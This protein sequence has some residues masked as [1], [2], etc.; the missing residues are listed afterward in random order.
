MN[1][2]NTDLAIYSMLLFG[3]FWGWLVAAIVY[4]RRTIKERTHF[5]KKMQ[6][7]YLTGVTDGRMAGY[8]QALE[9]PTSVQCAYRK[10]INNKVIAP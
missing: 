9:D 3:L 6:S 8:E 1:P 10:M 4:R 2:I 5:L 7:A